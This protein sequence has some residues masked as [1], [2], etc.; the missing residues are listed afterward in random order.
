MT[1]R[2]ATVYHAKAGGLASSRRHREFASL[3]PNAWMAISRPLCL[4]PEGGALAAA[5]SCGLISC[6][7]LDVR[8]VGAIFW[9]GAMAEGF[10]N[11]QFHIADEA[12][13]RGIGRR[14]S[15]LRGVARAAAPETAPN[16]ESTARMYLSAFL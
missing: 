14:R 6:G 11:L 10:A 4:L 13:P 5:S 7:F 1:M 9:E 3:G 16:P 2:I 12:G 15:A 8:L